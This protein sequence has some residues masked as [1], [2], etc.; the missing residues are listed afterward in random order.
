VVATAQQATPIADRDVPQRKELLSNRH[1]VV[2]TVQLAPQEATP[3]HRHERDFISV[4]VSGGSVRVTL[5]G[6]K[7]AADK[8]TWGEVR[9][10]QA[11]FVHATQNVGPGPFRVTF[12]DFADP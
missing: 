9:Y 1:V 12:I 3:L 8:L 7:P 2:S 10:H 11:P 5:P 4:Y 6:S